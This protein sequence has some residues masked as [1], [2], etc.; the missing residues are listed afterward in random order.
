MLSG[1]R[2]FRET[3]VITEHD[4]EHGL[5]CLGYEYE[6]GDDKLSRDKYT[7]GQ[8]KEV[9]WVLRLASW[10]RPKKQIF[11]SCF[12]LFHTKGCFGEAENKSGR[13]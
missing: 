5:C 2:G 10:L 13:N 1:H 3:S 8:E 9:I 4:I 12:I 7:V 6:H 11:T